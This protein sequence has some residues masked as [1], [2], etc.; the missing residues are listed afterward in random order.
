M[1]II[2]LVGPPSTGKT[3]TLNDL[4]AQL[5]QG[6]PNPPPKIPIAP[7]ADFECV[8]PYQGK[9]AAIFS[10]GDTEY[11]NYEAIIK[12]CGIVDVLILAHSTDGSGKM[13]LPTII[14]ACPQHHLIPK[15]INNAADCQ[16]IISNI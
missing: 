5:T 2:L 10:M 9:Q 12:Y 8:I 1:K 14:A 11:R 7:P 16:S 6:L 13:R 4:Y 3:T 15:T